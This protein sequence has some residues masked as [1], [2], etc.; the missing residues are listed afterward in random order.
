MTCLGNS[1]A[2]QQLHCGPVLVPLVRGAEA[3]QGG[4]PSAL[5]PATERSS[6]G[7]FPLCEATLLLLWGKASCWFREAGEFRRSKKSVSSNLL[8]IM[9]A[10][11]QCIKKFLH[12]VLIDVSCFWNVTQKSK[13]AYVLTFFWL[14]PFQ[15]FA[16]LLAIVNV[17]IRRFRSELCQSMIAEL[18]GYFLSDQ[19]SWADKNV[20][21]QMA[22][23]CDKCS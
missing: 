3:D 21:L 19:S 22:F 8:K 17:S 15:H 11:L 20:R 5:R 10:R 23:A 12:D 18:K 2:N 16:R 13:A 9:A 6:G 7:A 4:I 1:E 14:A